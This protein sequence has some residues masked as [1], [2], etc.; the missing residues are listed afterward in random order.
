MAYQKRKG[1]K[2]T[3]TILPDG[4]AK[5]E[6]E[7]ESLNAETAADTVLL[8]EHPGNMEISRSVIDRIDDRDRRRRNIGAYLE[9]LERAQE[10]DLQ[11]AVERLIRETETI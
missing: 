11:K 10:M 2:M 9:V 6:A 5:I 7:L 3:R 4:M 1:A 8:K